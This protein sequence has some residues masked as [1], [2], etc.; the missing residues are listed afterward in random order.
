MTQRRPSFSI[1]SLA[2]IIDIHCRCRSSN[3]KWPDGPGLLCEKVQSGYLLPDS[4]ITGYARG[5]WGHY[6]VHSFLWTAYCTRADHI[7]G[8][9]DNEGSTFLNFHHPPSPGHFDVLYKHMY[10]PDVG[11]ILEF[12]LPKNL[13]LAEDKVI[14]ADQ[15]DWSEPITMLRTHWQISPKEFEISAHI[16]VAFWLWLIRLG[17]YDENLC[18][19]LNLS[20]WLLDQVL[21]PEP[22]RLERLVKEVQQEWEADR[23]P[24]EKF[25]P[26]LSSMFSSQCSCPSQCADP[27]SSVSSGALHDRLDEEPFDR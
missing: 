21:P 16:I 6:P 9:T 4:Y 8:F 27:H 12:C 5:I 11:R 2:T 15:Q 1:S 14:H 13:H 26:T 23:F 3:Q 10:I 22:E 20:W 17:V 7:K 25:E 18:M 24:K 19:L